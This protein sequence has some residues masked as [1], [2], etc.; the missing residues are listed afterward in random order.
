MNSIAQQLAERSDSLSHREARGAFLRTMFLLLKHGSAA[1]ARDHA[2]AERASER[3]Q[4]IL[5]KAA[6]SGGGLDN[7]SAIGDYTNISSAFLES[8][9][10]VSVFDS[11]LANGMVRVPLRSRGFSITTGITGSVV[12]ERSVK[13][14]SSLV[15]GSQLVEPRKAASIVIVTKELADFSGAMQLFSAELV[16]GTVSATD[17]HFLSALISAT[18]PTPSAG[19]TLSNIGTDFDTLLSAV[20]TYAGS[21]L[22]YVASPSNIKSIMTKSN[23]GGTP[24]YPNVGINGG[25]IF[26]DVTAIASDAIASTAAL[27][28]DATALAGNSDAIIPGRSEQSTSQ[29]ESS[30]D[31]P[32]TAATTTLSLWQSDMLALRTERFFGYTIMRTTGIASLS[33]VSY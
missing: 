28:V 26:P 27:L 23:A 4:A 17:T 3:V 8:L 14:I 12:P 25:E 19:A 29:L 1:E 7:W 32:P 13:P 5:Q 9:R 2:K 16:K 6:V 15:L 18:T 10:G 33:G 11:I 22:Y 31:S 20:T 30:P 24:A 21:R